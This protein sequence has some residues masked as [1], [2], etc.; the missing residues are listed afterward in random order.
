V[1]KFEK[2]FN[3]FEFKMFEI[4]KSL[5]KEKKKRK[6]TSI[7]FIP[8]AHLSPPAAAR[9]PRL[10]FLFSFVSLTSRPHLS[11]PPSPSFLPFPLLCFTNHA[12]PQSLSRMAASF[13]FHFQSDDAN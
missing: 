4:Q 6:G 5:K 10:L 2:V 8:T 1:K 3:K 7:P 12:P 9:V 13:P 11:A